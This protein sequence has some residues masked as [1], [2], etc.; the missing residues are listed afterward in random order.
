MKKKAAGIIFVLLM[1]TLMAL[2]LHVEPVKADVWS[3]SQLSWS[4]GAESARNHGWWFREP[5]E[6]F[7][8]DFTAID[9][10]KIDSFV[11]VVLKLGVTNRKDGEKGLDGLVDVTINPAGSPTTTF[12]DVL[13]DNV[14]P[15]NHVRD[16]NDPSGS[17]NALGCP[18]KVPKSYIVSGQLKVRVLRHIDSTSDLPVGP[19]STN[20]PILQY[21]TRVPLNVYESDDGHKVHLFVWTQ[22]GDGGHTVTSAGGWGY[23]YIV[24]DRQYTV[25]GFRIPID[26]LGLLAPYIGLASMVCV[27]TAATAFYVKRSKRK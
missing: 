16:I 27:V 15:T 8:F 17:Y 5:T 4:P 3:T 21:P 19:V 14:D 13:L 26:T 24:S 18:L 10:T 23:A 6:W 9:T 20:Q 25:G 2:T 7:Q 12:T 11:W 1:A 22:E